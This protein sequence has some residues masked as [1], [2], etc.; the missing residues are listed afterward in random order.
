MS[1]ENKIK[2][3]NYQAVNFLHGIMYDIENIIKTTPIENQRDVQLKS[4]LQAECK[5]IHKEINK[6]PHLLQQ[7]PYP[8]YQVE[9]EIKLNNLHWKCINFTLSLKDY[10]D[11]LSLPLCEKLQSFHLIEFIEQF[12]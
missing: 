4:D 12:H 9:E 2:P 5:K 1:I 7:E 10:V 11:N 6:D 8:E 3:P